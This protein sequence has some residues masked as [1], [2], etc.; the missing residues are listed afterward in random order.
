[1]KGEIEGKHVSILFDGTT[2]VCE[3]LLRYL[4]SD[5]QVQ[6]H[7]CH[8]MLLSKSV[9]GEELARQL[10]TALSTELSI[11][12]SL[13]V[14]AMH[15]RAAVNMAANRTVTIVYNHLLSVGCWSHTLHHVGQTMNIPILEEFTKLWISLFSHDTHIPVLHKVAFY[16]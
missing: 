9:T 7:V 15:Y 6:Q 3:A 16:M 12:S 13:V 2:H 14:A 8:L 4:D 5:W 11:A 1:M 10:L